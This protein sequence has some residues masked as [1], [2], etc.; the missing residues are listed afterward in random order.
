MALI[1]DPTNPGGWLVD[2][3]NRRPATAVINEYASAGQLPNV[4]TAVVGALAV[5]QGVLHYAKANTNPKVADAWQAL[6]IEFNQDLIIKTAATAIRWVDPT[7][8]HGL[9]MFVD[10]SESGST[11]ESALYYRTNPNTWSFEDGVFNPIVTFFAPTLH[12]EFGGDVYTKGELTVGGPVFGETAYIKLVDSGNDMIRLLHNN[13]SGRPYL[14]FWNQNA[15]GTMERKGFVGY[16]DPLNSTSDISLASDFGRVRLTS[17]T[18]NLFWNAG[19]LQSGV[20]GSQTAPVYGFFND[21]DTG[22]YLYGTGQLGFTTQGTAKMMLGTTQNN[23]YQ[24][25]D[26]GGNIIKTLAAGTTATPAIGFTGDPNTGLRRWGA[27][28]VALVAGGTDACIAESG[29]FFARGVWT[30]PI[31]STTGF[32]TRVANSTGQLGYQSSSRRFKNDIADIDL[33][34]AVTLIR[35]LRPREYTPAGPLDRPGE[36]HYGLIAE[37]VVELDPSLVP[38][39]PGPECTDDISD[40]DIRDNPNWIDLHTCE[41]VPGS[42]HY[43]SIIAPILSAVS[44]LIDRFESVVGQPVINTPEPRSTVPGILQRLEAIEATI[45]EDEQ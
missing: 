2:T 14:S 27:D 24:M 9:E 7:G 6:G 29:N 21:T 11:L 28:S 34:K 35:G 36:R 32:V 41:L 13:D 22:M 16:P 23:M 38:F 5:A 25:L 17:E 26:M 39:V 40:E 8:P 43:E 1:P 33:T 15:S 44:L 31:G 20:D 19:R 3:D 4:T 37:E 12:T 18:V 10:G 45:G 42:V 30:S